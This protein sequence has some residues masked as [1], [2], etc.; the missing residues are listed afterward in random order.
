LSPGEEVE[1]APEV[2]QRAGDAGAAII[3]PDARQAKVEKETVAKVPRRA[4]RR[5]K[6]KT[7]APAAAAD[8]SR[9]VFQFHSRNNSKEKQGERKV[10]TKKYMPSEASARRRFGWHAGW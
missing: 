3:G 6:R 4:G 2:K 10:N 1:V 7:A 9:V 8:A 5:R